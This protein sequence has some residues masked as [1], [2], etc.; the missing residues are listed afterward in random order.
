MSFPSKLPDVGTT[1][2][3]VMSRLAAEHKAIN[4]SQGFP[5]FEADPR[6]ISLVEKA[7]REGQ[8]QYA[9]MPGLPELNAAIANK[10]NSD[11]GWMP[12]PESEITISAGGTQGIYSAIGCVIRP[13]DEVIAFEPSY[14]CY[15]PSVKSFG[16]VV[17]TVALNPPDY[18]VDW[19]EVESK[20]T[21]RTRIIMINT[22]H[23]PCG[24]VLNEKDMHRLQEI[25]IRHGLY[26]ISDEVYEHI[27]FDG[28]RHESVLRYPELYKRTFV[29]FSFGKSLHVT[30]WKTGY[31]IAP[32]EL[33]V[34]YRKNHQF[35]IFSANRPIQFAVAEY[36]NQFADFHALAGFY[37]AKRDY[38]VEKMKGLPFRFLKCQGSYF[39][40]ADYSG[41]SEM[42]DLEYAKLLTREAGVATIPMSP[43][44]SQGTEGKE[45]CGF[46]LRKRKARWMRRR[47]DCGVISVISNR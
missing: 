2:F 28:L 16:G 5:D 19:E 6:L 45:F 3:T 39:I 29:I 11:Y 25:V 23:N 36:M 15:I 37:Q 20:I 8:N 47:G 24:V 27:I 32:P 22:P 40:L 30:G 17:K 7:M 33:T 4:L 38:F 43:F 10:I 13:G 18:A 44:Y 14:D 46:V 31:V 9:P 35:N 12:D 34:E 42:A 26:V 41:A 21:D 1:I